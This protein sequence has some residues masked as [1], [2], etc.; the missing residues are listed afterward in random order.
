MTAKISQSVSSLS[1]L[2]FKLFIQLNSIFN[3]ELRA[4]LLKNSVILAKNIGQEM[5]CIYV[6]V[7]E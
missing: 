3:V 1:H 6:S 2:F 5:F 7:I 4:K